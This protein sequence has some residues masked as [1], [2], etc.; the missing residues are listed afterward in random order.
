MGEKWILRE[1]K[2]WKAER[3][4]TACR[5]DLKQHIGS[6]VFLGNVIGRVFERKKRICDMSAF[7]MV[8][9]VPQRNGYVECFNG[10]LRDECLNVCWFGQS[11]RFLTFLEC[12]TCTSTVP[13]TSCPR[14]P[15]LLYSTATF[16]TNASLPA[17]AKFLRHNSVPAAR[18][19]PRKQ[20]IFYSFV[21][22]IF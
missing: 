5:T 1:N 18:N 14:V 4:A 7:L 2:G 11:G 15:R 12:A 22:S 16:A 21:F 19:P 17:L 20:S 10:K 6:S 3:Q 8:E 13:P 9:N